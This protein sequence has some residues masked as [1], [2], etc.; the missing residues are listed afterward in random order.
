[1]LNRREHGSAE[2]RR[3]LRERGCPDDEIEDALDQLADKGW[4]DDVRAAESLARHWARVG[5]KG[6]MRIAQE[7]K[8]RGFDGH[9]IAKGL[10]E[11]ESEGDWVS[12]CTRLVEQRGVPEDWEGRQKLERWLRGRGFPH[13]VVKQALARAAR[14]G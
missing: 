11:A 3:K 7:L 14:P 9:A 1:M 12:R 10:E 8:A 13:D 6:P 2:L 5:R 4:L